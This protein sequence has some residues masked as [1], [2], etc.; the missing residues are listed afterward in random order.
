LA[1]QANIVFPDLESASLIKQHSGALPFHNLFF[2]TE[3]RLATDR[4]YI[5][6]SGAILRD[7]TSQRLVSFYD[8]GFQPISAVCSAIVSDGF[9]FEKAH[10]PFTVTERMCRT[11][12][13]LVFK[14]I[15]LGD[16]LICATIGKHIL[17]INCEKKEKYGGV[18]WVTAVK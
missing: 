5:S 1:A 14:D 2:P 6:V 7:D 11:L 3:K 17:Y 8:V 12:G 13:P 15:T 16:P 4:E 18:L 9:N 10:V